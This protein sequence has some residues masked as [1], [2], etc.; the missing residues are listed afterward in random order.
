MR[1]MFGKKG[2]EGEVLAWWIIAG[3]VLVIMAIGI[4]FI[5]KNKGVDTI[6]FLKNLFRFR[7]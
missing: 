5:L 3:I 1:I 4:G 2:I 6:G 7:R